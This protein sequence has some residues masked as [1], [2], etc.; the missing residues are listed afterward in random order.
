MTQI[1]LPTEVDARPPLANGFRGLVR[2]IRGN[3]SLAG[4]LTVIISMI[5][6]SVVIIL[7]S[8][9]TTTQINN[10]A[11]A[12]PSWDHPLGTDSLARDN[13]LRLSHA[14]LLGLWIS[15]CATAL[16]AV[17][18]T[19]LGTVAGFAGGH[20]DNIIMRLIDVMLSIPSLLLALVLRVMLGPGT[21]TLIISLAV[22]SVPAF[23]R[24]MR[25]PIITIKERDFVT[26]ARIAGVNRVRIALRHLLPN[27][28]TPLLVQFAATASVAVLL[29]S[30]LSFLGAGILPPD[31]SAGRMISDSIRFMQRDMLLV[32][33]PSLVLVTMTIGW[34]LI[35]DGLQTAMSPRKSDLQIE[36][37]KKRRIVVRPSA[38]RDAR[39]TVDSTTE[40]GAA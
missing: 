36:T 38:R 14:A 6:V 15:F 23:A 39:P 4:G 3:P 12:L 17:V 35:A 26:A 2:F 9:Y 40:D 28:L 21:F 19:L 16:G 25:A 34:N 24:I 30:V 11:F 29:E 1:A 20:V 22:I 18:G 8:P 32:L 10:D 7:T 27:A 37:D 5:V 33:L 31:P 13:A